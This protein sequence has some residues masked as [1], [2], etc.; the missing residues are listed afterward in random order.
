[1]KGA[2]HP[3]SAVVMHN[4]VLLEVVSLTLPVLVQSASLILCHPSAMAQAETTLVMR[5]AQGCAL[6]LAARCFLGDS[7][8]I[9][10]PQGRSLSKPSAAGHEYKCTGGNA[11]LV[12]QFPDQFAC[13]DFG[14]MD[15]RQTMH[16]TLI[17]LPLRT[18]VMTQPGSL[19]KVLSL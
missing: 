18:E 11:R 3:E 10:D 4:E 13:W 9:W 6:M 7:L 12:D 16:S 5:C 8:V 15:V 14:G 19:S 1:M 17:R 2:G